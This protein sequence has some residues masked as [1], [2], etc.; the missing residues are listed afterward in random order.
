MKHEL[1]SFEEF[2]FHFIL[3]IILFGLGVLA[4]SLLFWLSVSSC[5]QKPN[6][7]SFLLKFEFFVYSEAL[8]R[9]GTGQNASELIETLI[10]LGMIDIYRE[11]HPVTHSFTSSNGQMKARLDQFWISHELVSQSLEAKIETLEASILDHASISLQIMWKFPK[12]GSNERKLLW[13]QTNEEIEIWKGKMR[14]RLKDQSLDVGSEKLCQKFQVDFDGNEESI[15]EPEKTQTPRNP[16]S[17]LNFVKSSI[18]FFM[19]NHPKNSK[20]P[21]F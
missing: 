9:Q 12:L 16:R 18:K 4:I 2:A 14:K 21:K 17:S 3:K 20:Q 10:N 13:P 19:G 15:K 11:K 6:S 1:S 8:M 5:Q 7:L